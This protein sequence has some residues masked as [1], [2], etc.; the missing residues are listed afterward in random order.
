[1]ATLASAAATLLT[2]VLA[3]RAYLRGRQARRDAAEAAAK[4]IAEADAHAGRSQGLARYKGMAN[5]LRPKTVEELTEQRKQLAR[6]GMRNNDAV[7]FYAVLRLITLF[8]GG[9]VGFALL[10]GG[11]FSMNALF[12]ANLLFAVAFLGPSWWLRLRIKNR[13]AA[14]ARSLPPT[15]DLIVTCMEAGLGLEQ[16]MARVTA[17]IDYS[18]PEMSEEL[19]VVVG[20][21]RAGLSVS[22]TFKKF[23]DRV[24]SDAVRNLSQ[25]IIQSSS[26]GAPLG[27]TLREYAS[28]A[29]RQR[30]LALE[31]SAGKIA[32]GLTLPLTLCL[33]P[34]AVIT[35]LGPAALMVIKGLSG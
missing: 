7:S 31:E 1:M 8:A 5:V 18:D 24:T 28:S 21:M 3:C 25:V 27:P 11:G 15:L 34:S 6:A 10:A 13:Q 30:E 29:R 22:A 4:A 14:L 2:V 19:A 16:A 23:A 33:L 12:L 26:L 17:E 35:I 20:E 9:T 32:A